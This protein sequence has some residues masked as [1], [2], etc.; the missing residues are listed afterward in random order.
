VPLIISLGDIKFETRTM[1][2]AG[3]IACI[4]FKVKS[5]VASALPIRT[6]IPITIVSQMWKKILGCPI[7]NVI[8]KDPR[9]IV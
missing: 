6:D 8:M 2:I 5:R 7:S 4:K 9:Y 1:M 3:Y